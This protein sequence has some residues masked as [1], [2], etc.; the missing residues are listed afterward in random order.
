MAE[1]GDAMSE[2]IM[3]FYDY[4][5]GVLFTLRWRTEEEYRQG[6]AFL[7]ELLGPEGSVGVDEP[8]RVPTYYLE[9]EQQRDALHDF[10]RKLREAAAS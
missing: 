2:L 3:D 8:G 5:T 4:R 9:N 10:R 6:K 7:A 1:L